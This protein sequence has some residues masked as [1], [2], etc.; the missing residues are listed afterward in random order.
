M[1]G[2][3]LLW[4]VFAMDLALSI[5][6]ISKLRSFLIN[7]KNQDEVQEPTSYVLVPP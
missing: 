1:L 6:L 7:W 5:T 2:L 4:F 3:N